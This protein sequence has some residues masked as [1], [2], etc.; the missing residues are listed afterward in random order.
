MKRA[1]LLWV[2]LIVGMLATAGFSQEPIIELKSD[3]LE[4]HRRPAV[5]FSHEDHEAEIACSRCHH[6]YDKFGA[7]LSEDGQPCADCH[8]AAATADNRV[9]LINAFHMQCKGCH[10][11]L[12]RREGT[13]LP[14]S[15]GQCHQK[16]GARI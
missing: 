16:S 1:A 5:T 11:N 9:A 15:C 3:P 10:T 14:V 4:P 2:I 13:D 7:N 12:N 6:D 8:E